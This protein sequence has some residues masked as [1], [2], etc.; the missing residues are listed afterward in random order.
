[1]LPL[2]FGALLRIVGA[3]EEQEVGR[4]V[5]LDCAGVVSWRMEK[6]GEGREERGRVDR[7][8]GEKRGERG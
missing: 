3:I 2:V 1:M 8:R 4:W 6:V 7:K 5:L